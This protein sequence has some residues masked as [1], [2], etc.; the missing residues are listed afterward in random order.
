MRA[1]NRNIAAGTVTGATGSGFITAFPAGD[2]VPNVSNLNYTQ[3]VTVSNLAQPTPGTGPP[4]QVAFEN[5]G[6]TAGDVQLIVDEF[7]YYSAT[8]PTG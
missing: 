8:W 3:G 1:R 6:A 2:T 5:Q 7:G 4:G